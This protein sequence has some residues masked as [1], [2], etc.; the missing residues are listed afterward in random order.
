MESNYTVDVSYDTIERL[1]FD[2]KY[3][4]LFF[5]KGNVSMVDRSAIK[6]GT[7]NQLMDFIEGKTKKKFTTN[8]SILTMSLRDL[9]VAVKDKR[10][11]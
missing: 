1:I 5:G 10:Q 4:Y 6:G 3:L 11:R 2:E 9:I 7:A 8:K